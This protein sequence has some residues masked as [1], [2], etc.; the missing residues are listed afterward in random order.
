MTISPKV[1]IFYTEADST[2]GIP[3]VVLQGYDV[4]GDATDT[5]GS[6]VTADLLVLGYDSV[7]KSG[8]TKGTDAGEFA[9]G[10]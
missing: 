4:S 10:A 6:V 3:C 9:Y 5:E 1:N 7:R 2:V 8:V